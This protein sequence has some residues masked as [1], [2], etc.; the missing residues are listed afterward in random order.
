[1]FYSPYT[2]FLLGWP[3]GTVHHGYWHSDC[4][5][6]PSSSLCI[7]N[8]LLRLLERRTTDAFPRLSGF[9]PTWSITPDI[10]LY[11]PFPRSCLHCWGSRDTSLSFQS[12]TWQ[13][14]HLQRQAASRF[15]AELTTIRTA[16]KAAC[17]PNC[18][19]PVVISQADGFSYRYKLNGYS[20]GL[21]TI[22]NVKNII[23]II[24]F[25]T[26][27]LRLRNYTT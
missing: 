25:L 13:C 12:H 6:D 16:Q 9:G 23:L 2:R 8:N 4:G 24:L 3:C 20:F 21:R 26:R 10:G 5:L 1:M 15:C 22:R 7:A 11:C 17:S 18:S 14:L 19:V 27:N